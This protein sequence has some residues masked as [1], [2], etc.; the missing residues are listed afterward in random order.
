MKQK[1]KDKIQLSVLPPD[2]M[3]YG[4]VFALSCL[5][6]K[7]LTKKKLA[8]TARLSRHKDHNNQI[9]STGICAIGT[10]SIWHLGDI[11]VIVGIDET[12]LNIIKLL[13]IAV[14]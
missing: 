11:K 2:M 7:M 1:A 13:C 14:S 8:S 9:F 6:V 10:Y 5:E 4:T 3:S 12:A